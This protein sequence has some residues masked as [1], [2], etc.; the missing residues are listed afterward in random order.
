MCTCERANTETSRAAA[1]AYSCSRLIKPANAFCSIEVSGFLVKISNL[2]AA[3]VENELAAMD[4]IKFWP[5]VLAA[6]M[7]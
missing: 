3:N 2:S 7:L 5:K 4:V 1:V 6:R